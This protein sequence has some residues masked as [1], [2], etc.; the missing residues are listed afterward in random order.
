MHGYLT[1]FAKRVD[2][3]INT[4]SMRTKKVEV[5]GWVLDFCMLTISKHLKLLISGMTIGQ[6]HALTKKTTWNHFWRRLPQGDKVVEDQQGKAT[7]E[8][9]VPIC[10]W[11][12]DF[13]TSSWDDA[14]KYVVAA[15]NH[16]KGRPLTDHI[17]CR[18]RYMQ[19][20]YELESVIQEG[21][22]ILCILHFNI[23]SRLALAFDME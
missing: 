16:G 17:L 7:L 4:Y 14:K 8:I 13:P 22:I 6:L 12:N 18:R 20:F 3:F 10:Q 2:W 5:E 9:V 1:T 15:I 19:K 11:L 23:W 21:G